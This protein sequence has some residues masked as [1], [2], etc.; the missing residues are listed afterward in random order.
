MVRLDKTPP[1][2]TSSFPDTDEERKSWVR[3][4]I[5]WSQ[6]VF[7]YTALVPRLGKQA[8]LDLF[9]DGPGYFIGAKSW[10]PFIAPHRAFVLFLC[11]DQA[12]LRGMNTRGDSVTLEKLEANEA[13]VRFKNHAYFLL[14]RDTAHLKPMISFAD[15]REIFE[16]VWR[17]RASAAGWGLAIEYLNPNGLEILFRLNR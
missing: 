7:F 15:Y 5:Y 11:W 14:Y 17:S 16:T 10:V 12:N 2:P 13:V 9:R 4:E 8:F 1:P 6:V 3:E